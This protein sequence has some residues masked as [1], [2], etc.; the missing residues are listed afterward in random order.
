[1]C[2]FFFISRV[3]YNNTSNFFAIVQRQQKI[4]C[5]TM[6]VWRIAAVRTVAQRLNTTK[7][8]R[9][10]SSSVTSLLLFSSTTPKTSSI[11]IHYHTLGVF[12]SIKLFIVQYYNKY[13]DVLS[14]LVYKQTPGRSFSCSLIDRKRFVPSKLY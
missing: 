7:K 5:I 3:I 12:T 10:S 8:M 14:I 9:A 4:Q 2:F 6:V 13:D 1:M 11:I